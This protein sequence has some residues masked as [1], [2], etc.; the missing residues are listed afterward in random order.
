MIWVE[1]VVAAIISSRN[2]MSVLGGVSW[3]WVVVVGEGWG[4][5]WDMGGGGVH[6]IGVFGVCVQAVAAGEAGKFAE[7]DAVVADVV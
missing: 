6:F 3:G 4:K 1:V 2:S 5:G 7:G